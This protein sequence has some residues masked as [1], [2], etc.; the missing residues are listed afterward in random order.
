MPALLVWVQHVDVIDTSCLI[1]GH[2]EPAGFVA[3]AAPAVSL[4]TLNSQ[5]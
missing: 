4:L 5:P 1:Q 3:V 2:H